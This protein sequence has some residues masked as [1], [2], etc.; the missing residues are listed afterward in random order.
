METPVTAAVLD[1]A[2][3]AKEA[4]PAL[5]RLHRAEKD[6]VLRAMADA[7]VDRAGEVVAANARDLAAADAAGIAPG[8]RD[9]LA[10]D[11]ERVAAIAE[12]LR[13]AA[14]L[15]DPIGEVIRGSM[16]DNGLEL[17]EVRVPMGVIGM[18]YEARPNV[19]V[20]AAGLALKAGSAVVLRGGSAALHSNTALIGVLR[21]V[22][23]AHDLPEDLIVGIDA[24]GREGVDVLMR[25]R[26]L[27]DVLIPRG[28][29]GLIRRVVENSLVPVI[30]TGTGKTHILVDASADP[31]QA[32]PIVVNAKTQRIGVCNALETLLVH[33]EI[34]EEAL[35]LLAAPLAE[36]G[37]RLHADDAAREI[38]AAAGT[39]AEVVPAT[40]EDW[41]TEYLARELAVAVV[42][43]LDAALAHIRTHSTGH[44]ESILTRDLRSQQRFLAEVDSAVVMANASTRFSD[45]GEFGFGA[46]I[47]I[48]TQKLH[49]RGPMGLRE[50]TASKWLVVGQ[51]HVRP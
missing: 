11:E 37:V 5:A 34:A 22:L 36:A 38:L 1:A 49:A 47:G 43:D 16:L 24:H 9:R 10:L 35:P 32:V 8:L 45:G 18:V 26:G 44:T 40:A 20:D 50:I 3:A 42:E 23:A 39:A 33:R 31:A 4:Q 46:E 48:S 27:V 12:Q 17:R 13:D 6:R 15:P 28:G 2:R 19:T 7:L 51:G 30:E 21:S 41:D 25:A 14:A 29:A